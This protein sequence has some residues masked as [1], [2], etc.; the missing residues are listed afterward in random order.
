MKKLLILFSLLSICGSYAACSPAGETGKGPAGGTEQPEGPGGEPSEDRPDE[1]GRFLV[2]YC[3]RS[4]NTRLVAQ[5][6]GTALDGDILEVEPAVPYEEEYNAM[7]SRAQEELAAIDQ[8]HYPAIT[9]QSPDFDGYEAV[10][11]GYPIWYGSMTTPLQSFLHQYAPMLAGKRIAL[12]ATS[13]SSGVAT[14]VEEAK[15]LCPDSE[16]LDPALLLTASSL[17]Q[18]ESRIAAWLE[19]L[20]LSAGN[21]DDNMNKKKIRLAVGS[22]SF[23]ATLA[24]NSSA[25]A[26]REKLAEGDL[27]IRMDDYG[28]M[29]K[30]GSLGFSLPR[31]DARTT[32]APGDLIL[33]QGNSFV[34]YYGV[35]SWNFTRL[36][37]VDGVSTREQM[38][39]L[40]GGKGSITLTLSLDE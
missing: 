18:S 35:N 10:L 32:T 2:V 8:G 1:K 31:N 3:S 5:Q 19:Q 11:V 12:F 21:S 24:D 4:G 36:G 27:Q 34:V 25:D 28:D 26:L 38:L 17:S 9:T 22:R 20:N 40:L 7:L 14:S 29:E 30:V 16:I 15:F 39:E 37:K 33:Y 6:I 13:G 23:T